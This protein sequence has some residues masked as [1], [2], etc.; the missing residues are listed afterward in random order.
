MPMNNVTKKRGKSKIKISDKRKA[1]MDKFVDSYR[2]DFK[3]QR[4]FTQHDYFKGLTIVFKNLKISQTTGLFIIKCG[5]SRMPL[6]TSV[7]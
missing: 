2:D 3:I 5:H 4:R 1:V 7:S 6:N